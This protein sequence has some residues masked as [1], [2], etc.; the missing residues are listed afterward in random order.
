VLS[1]EVFRVFVKVYPL[2]PTSR[3]KTDSVQMLQKQQKIIIEGFL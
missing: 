2:L 1:L 3:F